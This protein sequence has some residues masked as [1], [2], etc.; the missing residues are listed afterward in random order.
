M[1]DRDEL[2]LWLRL[3]YTRQED[4]IRTYQRLMKLHE[5]GAPDGLY[6]YEHD[7]GLLKQLEDRLKK[8][9]EDLIQDEPIYD[10]YL[11]HVP[12]VGPITAALIIAYIDIEKADRPSKIWK[13]IGIDVVDGVGVS[14]S[15]SRRM[16]TP[17]NWWLKAKLYNQLGR[18]LIRYNKQYR[19]IYEY[20]LRKER[21]K[22]N[23]P[24]SD[25]RNCPH[26]NKCIK[27]YKKSKPACRLHIHLRAMRRMVKEFYIDLYEKWREL[28]GLPKVKP[29][30]EEKLGKKY[31]WRES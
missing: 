25:P 20:T 2:K 14:K 15:T 13:Y 11:K 30:Y 3:F 17:R 21:E 18:N 27:W 19:E 22:L 4:R 6:G 7:V 1:V 26:Y 16:N 29:Y 28:E 8:I 5:M 23:D 12:G 24:V 9:I 31:P 10:E